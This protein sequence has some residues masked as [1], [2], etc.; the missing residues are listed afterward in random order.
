MHR[1]AETTLRARPGR[2]PE[3]DRDAWRNQAARLRA[4]LLVCDMVALVLAW[5]VTS[6][7][8]GRDGVAEPATVALAG[9]TGTAL[10]LRAL[11]LY[12]SRTC[13]ILANEL[14]GLAR[15]AAAGGAAAAGVDAALWPPASVG[16]ATTGTGV[17]FLLLVIGRL[18][19]E[20]RLRWLRTHGTASRPVVLIGS[21]SH[22]EQLADLLLG[23]PEFGYQI[24]GYL[25]PTDRLSPRLRWLGPLRD[26]VDVVVRQGAGGVVIAAGDV[27]EADLATVTRE[28][29]TAGIH[30]LVAPGIVHVPRQRLRLTPVAHEP[31]LY[32]EPPRNGS[33]QRHGKRILDLVVVGGSLVVAAPLA[34][35]IA[36]AIKLDDGGPVLY[37]QV[38][39]GWHGRPFGMLKFRTMAVGAHDAA[40]GLASASF[41]KG[42]LFKVHEDPRVTRLG[43]LLRASNLDELP[44]LLNVLTGTMS[45]VGPRPALASEVEKFDERHLIRQTLRPG[46][47]GLW[48]VEAEQNELFSVY[49]HLDL[50]Y[51][52]DLSLGLDL[53]II[54]ATVVVMGAHMIARIVP[55]RR[56]RRPDVAGVP[57]HSTGL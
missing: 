24:V 50:V 55:T 42:P 29:A 14:R 10:A 16:R 36:L 39:I 13:S 46:I 48:Q 25:G 7:L 5:T 49:R 41:R 37:R 11:H 53:S 52:E 51:V 3:T 35:L 34:A 47:T 33:Y 31:L 57:R 32:V 19:Y 44:Q 54:V 27:Y 56:R 30:I 12:R 6:A 20:A 17:T 26:P 2:H 45:I 4:W 21:G 28:L 1:P 38:R 40:A 9:A 18:A 22:A 43:G 15:A 23:Q 8:V